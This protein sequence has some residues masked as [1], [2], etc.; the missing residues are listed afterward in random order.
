MPT[1]SD[2]TYRDQ[3]FSIGEGHALYE[4]DPAGG[5]DHIRVGDV[6]YVD[7]GL[8]MRLFNICFDATDAANSPHPGD[9]APNL[10]PLDIRHRRTASKHALSPG[11]RL[12]SNVSHR[13][14]SAGAKAPTGP[15]VCF[16]RRFVCILTFYIILSSIPISA[17][18]S[19]SLECHSQR[20]AALVTKGHA[21]R[22]DAIAKG[23]FSK[24]M[25]AHCK[26]WLSYAND[27]LQRDIALRDLILVTGCDLTKEWATAVFNE[28]GRAASIAFEVDA[29]VA[30]ANLGFWGRWSGTTSVPH[31]TWP[32]IPPSPL[33]TIGKPSV[34]PYFSTDTADWT[35]CVFI[36]GYR[37]ERRF[38]IGPKGMK[39]AAEP[40]DLPKDRTPSPTGPAASGE[41]YH[42]DEDMG[43]L[44]LMDLDPKDPHEVTIPLCVP[45]HL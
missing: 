5:Y 7:R 27:E 38:R 32:S 14:G 21:V 23:P 17:G 39:A 12:S 26:S 13:G 28:T 30:S 25:L 2:T 9:P 24:H 15:Y 16:A 3:M 22:H 18:A 34:D 31:R 33:S 37:V 29:Q 4:P 35:Q 1:H 11:V 6:G 20:G 10:T 42:S 19:V 45:L 8:F 36:R 44:M 40:V 41:G 43:E